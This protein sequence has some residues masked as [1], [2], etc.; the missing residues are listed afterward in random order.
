MRG[1][2]TLF[3]AI[4]P[5]PKEKQPGIGRNPELVAKRNTKLIYRYYFYTQLQPQRLD[6]SYVINTIAAEFDLSDY[7]LIIILQ[8]NHIELKKVFAEKPEKKQLQQKFPYL[9]WQ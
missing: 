4:L 7:R 8:E 6:Y 1:Q 9:S 3:A 5:P 2:H